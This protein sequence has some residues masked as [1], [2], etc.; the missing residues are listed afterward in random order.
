[1]HLKDSTC[2]AG[3]VDDSSPWLLSAGFADCGSELAYSDGKF[4]LSNTL[5]ISSPVVGGRVVGRQYEID[6]TCTYNSGATAAT[7]IKARSEVYT[8][9]TFDINDVQPADLSFEFGLNFFQSD[10]FTTAADL[11][12]GSF[13]PGAPLYGEITPTSALPAST[14]FSVTRCAVADTAIFASLYIL[15]TCP[16]EGTSFEFKDAQ[17]DAAAVR[18]SYES[19]VFPASADETTIDVACEVNICPIGSEDCLELCPDKSILVVLWDLSASYLQSLDGTTK[20]AVAQLSAPSNGYTSVAKHALVNGEIHIFGGAEDLYRIS[21]LDGCSFTELSQRL[22]DA[23]DHGSAALSIESGSAALIC[24]NSVGLTKSCEIFDGT[25]VRY[26]SSSS[27]SHAVGGLGLYK[28]QPT[29]IGCWSNKHR[30]TETLTPSGW[31]ALQDHPN[32][33]ACHAIVGLNDGSMLLIGGKND[34]VYVS[35]IWQLKDNTWTLVGNL[36]QAN[37][38][39]TALYIDQSIYYY[40]GNAQNAPYKHYK[41][42]LTSDE[43][44]Q[45]IVEFGTHSEYYN[46]PII[47]ESNE[48]FCV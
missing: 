41:I 28:G 25:E 16:V 17:S 10:A 1:M 8:E 47:V 38:F 24:F 9:L 42:D 11:V 22:D 4:T 27:Y 46:Y 48:E 40:A 21:K 43:Q 23:R 33:M 31:N 7:T 3:R 44:I 5:A 15:D 26:T 14:Q 19:F 12:G 35:A 2:S 30:F 36:G 34:N 18:F 39:G 32:K 29:T 20:S 6:F 13:T 37:A 45:S